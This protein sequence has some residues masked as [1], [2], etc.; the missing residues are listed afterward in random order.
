MLIVCLSRSFK[1]SG[2]VRSVRRF[3]INVPV[4]T[5]IGVSAGFVVFPSCRRLSGRWES[6]NRF[7]VSTFPRATFQFRFSGSSPQSNSS[8]SG[9]NV[10]ISRRWRDSQGVVGRMGIPLL[11]F[12]S[13]H[14]PAFPRLARRQLHGLLFLLSIVRRKRND[15]VPVSMM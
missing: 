8:R 9:G 12:H 11:D 15:S 5:S 2:I 14:T 6:G 10:G 3:F 4:L 7:L 1:S 13:F